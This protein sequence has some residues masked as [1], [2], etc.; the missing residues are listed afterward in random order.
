MRRRVDV[1]E[2]LEELAMPRQFYLVQRIK[3]SWRA[4]NPSKADSP[5]AKVANVFG[6]GTLG[7]YD[8]EYMGS[9]EFEWGAI[10]EA[11]DRLR[12][13]GNRLVLTEWEYMGHVFDFLYREKDG[14]PF[15]D[16]TRW[17]EGRPIDEYSGQEYEERPFYGKEMPYELQERLDG[18]E[19]PRFG[20]EWRTDVWWALGENVMWAFHDDGHL[21][22]MLESMHRTKEVSLRGAPS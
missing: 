10:P 11:F 21:T 4:D 15:E 22:Q 12:K 2:V 13:A 1:V 20:D 17:A 6:Y 14:E 16:W 19:K 9:A 18:A 3:R 8:L 7:D 5:L